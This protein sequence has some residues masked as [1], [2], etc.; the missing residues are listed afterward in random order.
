MSAPAIDVC[1]ARVK[2]Q[3]H[4]LESVFVAGDGFGGAQQ[5][6]QLEESRYAVVRV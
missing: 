4:R 2:E 3:L 1:L 6:G 5:R